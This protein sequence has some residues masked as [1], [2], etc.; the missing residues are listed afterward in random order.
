MPSRLT[1]AQLKQALSDKLKSSALDDSD[2]KTLKLTT[3][4]S[5]PKLPGLA[6]FPDKAGVVF[7]YFDLHGK[8]LKDVARVRYLEDTREGFQKAAGAKPLRYIQAPG[9]SVHLYL[10]PYIDWAA[11]AADPSQALLITEGE[12]KAACATKHGFP[13]I[14][15]GGVWSF[16]T[17]RD[18]TLLIKDFLDFVWVE[19][20]V[21]ICYDSDAVTNPDVVK[22]E[23]ALADEL[24]SM[25]ADVYI[26]RIP[27]DPGDPT[28]PRK[29]AKLGVDDYIVQYGVEAFAAMLSTE[30]GCSHEYEPSRAM[31]ELNKRFVFVRSPG[32]VYDYEQD[33][34]MLP[35]DFTGSQYANLWMRVPRPTLGK[36]GE[37]LYDKVQTAPEW[38]KWPGRAVL[39]R[40]SYRPGEGKV[41]H[42]NTL[43]TWPGWGVEKAV[44]GDVGPW[45]AMMDHLFNGDV[46]ERRWF[47]QWCACPFQQP[48][49]KL[50][51]GVLIW[52]PTQGSGKT[53]V[54]KTLM[55][56]YGQNATEIKDSD[57][58]DERREWA[59]NKQFVLA[60][61]I[62]GQ[63]NRKLANKLKTMITQK[64]LRINPKYIQ[65]YTVD[66]CINYYFT[67]NDPDALYL[68]DQDRRFFVYESNYVK[69]A[70]VLRKRYIA[71][72]ESTAGREALFHYF[73]NLPLDGFDP[74]AD[75]MQTGHKKEMT[76]ISKSAIG[77][78]VARL[79]ETPA[80]LLDAA[81]MKG[82]LYTAEELHVLFD[83]SGEK[84]SSANALSRELKRAG[85]RKAHEAGLNCSVGLRRPYIVRNFD[86][87]KAAPL[88]AMIA[89][90]NEHHPQ[91]G[92]T[93]AKKF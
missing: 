88:K 51:S 78:W 70:D 47:E 72:Y 42:D 40:L 82:D 50:A 33:L 9:T 18:V 1:P 52:S 74:Y 58:E 23:Q 75:A 91:L 87:W 5:V 49:V 65:S 45:H 67:S 90:Y 44:K 61:D 66:D 57:L 4:P 15:L 29:S 36:G 6:K 37:T 69:L 77:S 2:I 8:L 27:P 63:T 48:G 39:R 13:C 14:G 10:P 59:E 12:L 46:A 3:T 32:I 79:S 24:L 35:R 92:P 80:E 83:P 7:P 56:L 60:D 19:R 41:T 16:R 28:D 81:K 53:L 93:K 89:H 64:Y 38:L 25:K 11:F 43:N 71:W 26:T 20:Q 31:N 68:D 22:A 86:Q 30:T 17:K 62:T 21:L 55:A 76:S 34:Q 85:F 54:G 73:L 84:K